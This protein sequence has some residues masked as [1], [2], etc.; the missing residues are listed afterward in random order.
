[1]LF[2]VSP[3]VVIIH[4]D[5][6]NIRNINKLGRQ[7]SGP[8]FNYLLPPVSILGYAAIVSVKSCQKLYT[9]YWK[10]AAR[11]HEGK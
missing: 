7:L 6:A 8:N 11:S 5:Q 10:S 9:I 2:D 1:M 4:D 3:M